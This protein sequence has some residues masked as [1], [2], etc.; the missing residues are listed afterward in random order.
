MGAGRSS[1]PA[2]RVLAIDIGGSKLAAGFV[3]RAGAL[4]ERCQVPTDAGDGAEQALDRALSLGEE[5]L[6]DG[7]GGAAGGG[8]RGGDPVALGLSTNGLTR[9]DGVELAPAVPGWDRLQIPSRLRERFPGLATAILND[10]KAATLAELRWGA[11]R[12]VREGLY[13][14]LGTGV[15]AGIVTGGNLCY[16]ANGAAGEI[17]YL[18]P[19]PQAAHARRL[20]EALLEERLGGRGVARWA[21]AELGRPVTMAELFAAGSDDRARELRDRLVDEI[22]FWVANVAVVVDP[23]RVALGGGLMRAASSLCGEVAAAIARVGPFSV[24]VVPA[25]FGAESSLLGAGAIA[26]DVLDGSRRLEGVRPV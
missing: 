13:V 25:R 3:D 6:G 19:T 26:F 22:G 7:S 20:D 10:V 11:L 5:L 21:S 9:E 23:Q 16:G 2:E 18:A 4:T 15:A 1:A 17:G 14:N 24:E 8:A 12:D